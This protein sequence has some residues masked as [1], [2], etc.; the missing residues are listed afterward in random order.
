MAK[1]KS[2][3]ASL[4]ADEA[5]ALCK[6]FQGYDGAAKFMR[7]HGLVNP[8]TNRP[9][10]KAGVKRAAMR[11]SGFSAWRASRERERADTEKEFKR[12]ARLAQRAKRERKE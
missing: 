5:L 11:A 10:T 4:S 1:K 12:I 7:E 3:Q 6:R 2:S 8:Q 9:F